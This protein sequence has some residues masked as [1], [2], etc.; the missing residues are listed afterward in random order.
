M[1]VFWRWPCALEL[2]RKKS[3]W[4]TSRQGQCHSLARLSLFK[5]CHSDLAF[6]GRLSL[7]SGLSLSWVGSARLLGL[8]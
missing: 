7:A 2:L 3:S 5:K 6:Q 4:E 1:S 8:L